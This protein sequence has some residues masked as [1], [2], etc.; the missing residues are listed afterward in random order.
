MTRVSRS[1]LERIWKRPR[2]KLP[3]TP[4]VLEGI[5]RP[6][7]PDKRD[8][9]P[10][11]L[12]ALGLVRARPS[13]SPVQKHNLR[14]VDPPPLTAAQKQEAYQR[15]RVEWREENGVKSGGVRTSGA[16]RRP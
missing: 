13:K 16:G 4:L 7:E 14:V 5:D 2:G 8:K 12:M 1:P 15:S 6:K 3:P 11:I 10:R 9:I